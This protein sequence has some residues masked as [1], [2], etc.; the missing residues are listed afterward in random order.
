MHSVGKASLF[1]HAQTL[2]AKLGM[3]SAIEQEQ[4]RRR[5]AAIR[6]CLFVPFQTYENQSKG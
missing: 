3:H 5:F 6:S 1:M 4:W 2:E